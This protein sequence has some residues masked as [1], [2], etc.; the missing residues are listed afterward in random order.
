MAIWHK[1]VWNSIDTLVANPAIAALFRLW[2]QTA[3][4]NGGLPTVAQ[5]SLEALPQHQPNFMYLHAE[6][7]DFRYLHYGVDIQQYSKFDMT[8]HAVSEFKGELGDFFMARYREVIARKQ[9]LYT[10]HYADLAKSVVTWERLIM[11]LR[12]ENGNTSLLV[13]NIPL[14]SRHVLLD[15]VLN[16]SNDGIVALRPYKNAALEITGWVVLA[17]NSL[18]SQYLGASSSNVLGMIAHEAYAEWENLSLNARCLEGLGRAVSVDF[19]FSLTDSSMP[20]SPVIRHFAGH[21]ASLNDGCV[22]RVNDITERRIYENT[23]L[24]AKRAAES[25]A[26]AKASFLATMS[27][28]IRTPMN[29]IIGM[30]SLLLETELTA[31]QSE[32]TEV[33]RQSSESL[34]VVVNDI[35]D[36]SKIESGYLGLEWLPFELREVV[37]SSI[38]LVASTGQSDAQKK[39]IDIVYLIE[40]DVPRWIHGDPTRLR[41]VLVN[42]I[43]NALKFTQEGEVFVGV[44]IKAKGTGDADIEGIVHVEFTVS[45]TGI[46]IPEDKIAKLFQ[47]FSQVDSSTSRKYGGTGLGLAISQRLVAAMGGSIA[48]ERIARG[49]TCMRFFIAAEI[50]REQPAPSENLAELASMLANKRILVVDDNPTN[51]RILT[52]QAQRLGMFVQAYSAPQEALAAVLRAGEMGGASPY[53]LVVTDM[54]MPGMDGI[55][56]A[57]EFKAIMPHCPIVL[58]SSVSIAQSASLKAEALFESVLTKPARQQVLIDALRDAV[59]ASGQSQQAPHNGVAA[60]A[61]VA[62]RPSN[63]TGTSKKSAKLRAVNSGSKFDAELAK[64]LPLRILVAEDNEVNV[65]VALRLLSG[66]GY[67]ADIAADGVEALQAVE[68][69]PYDLVFMDVQM[70][71]MDGLEATRKIRQLLTNTRT[72]TVGAKVG[73]LAQRTLRIVGMSANAMRQH[74]DEAIDAGMDDYLAKPITVPALHAVLQ[75]AGEVSKMSRVEQADA[76]AV[77]IVSA[78][79]V[80]DAERLQMLVDMDDASDFLTELRYTFVDDVG[81]NLADIHANIKAAKFSDVAR[82]A[83]K[84]KGLSSNLGLLRLAEGA[85]ALEVAI[86]EQNNAQLGTQ[87]AKLADQLDHDFANALNALDAFAATLN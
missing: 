2:N 68:R 13:Y 45:D 37:E 83:H 9:P 75:Q 18:I 8:G 17:A 23:L 80:L 55:R 56:F 61:L 73:H 72:S 1:A 30:T 60:G 22:L 7:E 78:A 84:V 85:M 74:R 62:A 64:R 53:D 79:P 10:V 27:H 15:A 43:A 87:L 28:E 59:K 12:D 71:R 21:V 76:D 77:G 86:S 34:L 48:A 16:S 63:T 54:N 65:K 40:P 67:R 5:I 70:P 44:C 36:F 25:A 11:P 66:F 42:L 3:D 35:L 24:A 26:E 14:E 57:R 81:Q 69:Q 41:Q 58:L 82:L 31:D 4:K 51:L 46:G 47:P 6:G 39:N 32:F 19:N 20:E 33:I 29:G 38:D 50:A 52:L 49:G